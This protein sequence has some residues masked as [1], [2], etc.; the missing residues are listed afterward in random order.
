MKKLKWSGSA[1]VICQELA[2]AGH[3]LEVEPGKVY[4]LDDELAERLVAANAGW[5]V[6][7]AKGDEG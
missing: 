5:Q 6:V 4:E 1:D 3:G 7:K 2:D